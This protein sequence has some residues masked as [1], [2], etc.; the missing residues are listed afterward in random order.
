MTASISIE[1]SL[2]YPKLQ[3]LVQRWTELS[4]D[5]HVTDFSVHARQLHVSLDSHRGALFLENATLQ[6]QGPTDAAQDARIECN[7]LAIKQCTIALGE[8]A[9]TLRPAELRA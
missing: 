1:L 7:Q 4:T 6:A 2:E 8:I 3:E 5:V 9:E